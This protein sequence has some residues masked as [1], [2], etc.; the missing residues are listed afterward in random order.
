MGSSDLDR[1]QWWALVNMVIDPLSSIKSTE[2]LDL[3]KKD[4]SME[5]I[6]Y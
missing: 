2:F 4:C 1:G 6:S 3:L 5:L